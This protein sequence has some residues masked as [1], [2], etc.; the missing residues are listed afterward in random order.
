[1]GWTKLLDEFRS[2]IQ[3]PDKQIQLKP[4]G[5]GLVDSSWAHMD[6]SSKKKE[7]LYFLKLQPV[8]ISLHVRLLTTTS[9]Y[10]LCQK[11]QL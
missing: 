3:P 4:S 1:M 6:P 9:Y 7:L 10:H 2:V 8:I 5:T 11:T